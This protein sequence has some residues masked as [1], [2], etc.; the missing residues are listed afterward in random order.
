[1]VLFF[2]RVGSGNKGGFFIK[3]G[4]FKQKE[5][6]NSRLM[7]SVFCYVFSQNKNFSVKNS[8]FL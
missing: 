4:F 3:S 7:V 5:S 6:E 8:D 1:M 2:F